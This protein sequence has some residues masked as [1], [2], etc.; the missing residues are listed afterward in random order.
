MFTRL[1]FAASAYLD[2]EI[3]I[4]DEVLSVGDAAFQKKCLRKMEALMKSGRTVLFVSHSMSTVAELCTHAILLKEGRVVH[5]GLTTDVIAE[6]A[7]SLGG[8]A[9]ATVVGG[10]GVEEKKEQVAAIREVSIANK[11]GEMSNAF[12]INEDIV[13]RVKYEVFEETDGLQLALMLSRNL[14]EIMQ[15]FDTDS[16][17]ERLPLRAPGSYVSQL[18]LPSKF[19]KAGGYSFTLTIGTPAVLIEMLES[20]VQFQVLELSEVP[21]HRGYRKERVGHIICP[22]HWHIERVA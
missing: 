8:E 16:G 4:I 12:D 14:V 3:L 10:G 5:Q 2:P 13:I 6:Y 21:Q 15:T 11:N 7:R 19:L 9:K 22:G 18:S 20:V 17:N 1:A